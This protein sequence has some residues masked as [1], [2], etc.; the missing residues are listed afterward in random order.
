MHIVRKYRVYPTDK[1]RQLFIQTFGCCR[2]IWNQMLADTIEYLNQK[3]KMLSVNPATYKKEFPFLRNVD[4]HALCNVWKYQQSAFRTY[5][6]NKKQKGRKRGFP[7]FKSR[8]YSR[9]SYTTNCCH[10]NIRIDGSFIRLP[11]A[12]NVKI[13]MHREIPENAALK[14]VTVSMEPDGSFYVS[15]LF[16]ANVDIAPVDATTHIGLDYV[17]D[18]LYVDSNGHKAEMPKYYRRSETRLARLQRRLSRSIGSKKGETPSHNYEKLRRKVAK[19]HQHIKNQRKD[20]LHKQSCEITNRYDVIS[21]ESLDMQAMSQSLRLGKA[22]LDNGYGMF[23]TML[24]YKQERKGHYLV[25]VN[26]LFPSSQL[27]FQC[28][29]QNKITKDLSIRYIDCPVCGASYDR[30]VNAARN[31]DREGMRLLIA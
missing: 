19:L 23:V 10:N 11:K 14:S 21:I 28:G 16:E 30:D 18:G 31:I 13:V 4:A 2:F 25:R 5:F 29:Y 26:K 6:K 9:N 7:K 22:T 1:Q 3:H 24:A 27:C 15:V 12:G 20:F 8:K 17:S